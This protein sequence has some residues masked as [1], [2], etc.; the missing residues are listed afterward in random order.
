MKLEI[1]LSVSICLTGTLFTLVTETNVPHGC[2]FTLLSVE[3]Y[4]SRSRI[5]SFSF[6]SFNIQFT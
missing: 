1:V 4:T 5:I 3:Y 2:L 6:V